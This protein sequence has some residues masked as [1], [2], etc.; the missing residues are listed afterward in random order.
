[1]RSQELNKKRRVYLIL[2]KHT[3][4]RP[5]EVYTRVSIY[6]YL[7]GVLANGKRSRFAMTIN[8]ASSAAMRFSSPLLSDIGYREK[9]YPWHLEV[10]IQR[11]RGPSIKALGNSQSF[12]SYAFF[13]P[14]SESRIKINRISKLTP[15]ARFVPFVNGPRGAI[16][17]LEKRRNSDYVT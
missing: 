2:R 7:G 14:C 5:D 17:K 4:C 12:I 9:I 8:I 13:E 11:R 3:G 16:R 10:P 1:M 6:V 15:R